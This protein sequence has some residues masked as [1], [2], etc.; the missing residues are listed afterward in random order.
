MKNKGHAVLLTASRKDL[1]LFTC[2]S[3][4]GEV[5]TAASANFCPHC[6][7]EFTAAGESVALPMLASA[8]TKHLKCL[9]CESTLETDET[10]VEALASSVYCPVCGSEEVVPAEEDVEVEEVEEVE[11]VEA[12]DDVTV[13]PE[14]VEEVKDKEDDVE[15]EITGLVGLESAYVNDSWVFFKD[16]NPQFKVVKAKLDRQIHPV[17]STQRF[18]ELVVQ[19]IQEIGSSAL[20]EFSAEVFDTQETLDNIDLEQLA[21]NKLQSSVLP[22]FIDCLATAIEGATKGIF[23]ELN[24]ELKASFYDELVA[25]GVTSSVATKAIENS[26]KAAG[27]QVFSNFVLKA[28]DLLNKDD[29]AFRELKATIQAAGVITSAVVTED[30]IERSEIGRK[31][32]AGNLNLNVAGI[33]QTGVQSVRERISFR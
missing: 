2:P 30:E 15:D 19:R 32:I 18:P 11:D 31:L 17:F 21:Y 12:G 26:F 1:K 20:R 33:K 8:T 10:D 4:E 6:Y 29:S 14:D 7:T 13:D 3:C 5:I 25:S 9:A 22:K 16:G 27:T 28:M 24:A 23:T